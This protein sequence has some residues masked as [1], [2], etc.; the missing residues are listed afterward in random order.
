M[1]NSEIEHQLGYRPKELIGQP[2]RSFAY[3]K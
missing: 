3:R 1:I 2:V